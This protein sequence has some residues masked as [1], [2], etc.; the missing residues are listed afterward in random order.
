MRQDE[1]CH[2]CPNPSS[3]PPSPVKHRHQAASVQGLGLGTLAFLLSY[4]KLLRL[5]LL[6]L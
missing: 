2:I 5:K 4:L 3:L 6:L 1:L